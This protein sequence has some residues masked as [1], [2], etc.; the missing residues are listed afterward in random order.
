MA[1]PRP[2]EVGEVLDAS[3]LALFC[4][5]AET[6]NFSRAAAHLGLAQPIVT[7]KI[8][9]LE[10]ALGVELFV[11]SNRGCE[12]TPEG[13]LLAAKASGILLQLAQLK[14]EVSNSSDRVSGT[15]AIGVPTAAGTLLAPVLMPA[16]ASRWP[17]LRVE[18]VEA[19]SANILASALNRE[20]SLAL[21]YD[22]PTDVGL[23]S[24]PLLMERLHLIGTPEAA[25]RLSGLKRARV[26]DMA[27]LPLVLAIRAQIIRVLVE[28]AFAEEGVP[29][30]QMYEANSPLLLKTMVLQGLGFTVLSLG[31]VADEV[32]TGRLVA[33]PLADRGM[34]L[35]LTM[36]TTKE[37]GR[38]RVVQLMSELIVS[39]VHRM[40]NSGQ[41]PG[42]PQIMKG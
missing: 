37:Q 26:Q 39:E 1:E 28:D 30:A 41:W 23:I 25:K 13:D 40:A 5:V 20:V 7:R 27:A 33:I 31:S 32:S 22:P 24:R 6:R 34:S 18:L 12:L 36:V 15:I 16:I 2:S 8:R 10:E 3:L 38:L 42:S 17:E 11:R 4:R 19:V 29:L 14:E 21:L 9:R 35:T